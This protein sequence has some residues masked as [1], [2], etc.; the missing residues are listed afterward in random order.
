MNNPGLIS[1]RAPWGGKPEN[2]TMLKPVHLPHNIKEG[3]LRRRGGILGVVNNDYVVLTPG[4]LFIF[5]HATARNPIVY[6][7]SSRIVLIRRIFVSVSNQTARG[8][9]YPRDRCSTAIADERGSRCGGARR[10]RAVGRGARVGGTLSGAERRGAAAEGGGEDAEGHG[11]GWSWRA[12]SFVHGVRRRGRIAGREDGCER[13]REGKGKD[14]ADPRAYFFVVFVPGGPIQVFKG[15]TTWKRSWTGS[16]CY[17]RRAST[18]PSGACSTRSRKTE[19]NGSVYSTFDEGATL[20]TVVWRLELLASVTPYY[21]SHGIAAEDTEGAGS[22]GNPVIL[23]PRSCG[24]ARSRSLVWHT[25]LLWCTPRT[26]PNQH[27]APQARHGVRRRRASRLLLA[28]RLAAPPVLLAGAHPRGGTDQG[29]I[30]SDAHKAICGT[31]GE[32]KA[33][34]LRAPRR[35]IFPDVPGG[36][37]G[38]SQGGGGAEGFRPRHRLPERPGGAPDDAGH[39]EPVLRHQPAALRRRTRASRFRGS[40]ASWTR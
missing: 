5:E 6:H 34:A 31:G 17:A 11:W 28:V 20:I 35:A 25:S 12:F 40:A 38:R 22:L 19:R 1:M 36:E 29:E 33:V 23:R 8:W 13:R 4:A 32:V 16:T 37:R 39:E 21:Y 9:H 15:A 3:W 10:W 18:P 24:H 2:L 30:F 7:L 27:V 14:V 26:G